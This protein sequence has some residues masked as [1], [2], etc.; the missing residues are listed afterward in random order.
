M[1]TVR[2][3]LAASSPGE[4]TDWLPRAREDIGSA[5]RALYQRGW[6][7]GT[8]GNVSVSDGDVVVISASGRAKGRMTARDTVAVRL[9]D[10]VPLPGESER[11][12]AETSIH[13]AVYRATGADA[14]VIHAHSPYATAL[15]ARHERYTGPG[16]VL[17]ERWELAKGLGMPE[18]DLVALPVFLNR[19]DVPRIAQEVT[20][21]LGQADTRTPP[22]LLIARHG[23]TVWGRDL[24]QARNRLEC[25]EALC[26]LALL[27]DGHESGERYGGPA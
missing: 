4:A 25:V 13:L 19:S 9:A 11:P 24:D 27:T 18:P 20:E 17:L 1:T 7:E 8:S 3:T 12:S 22:A 10:G 6:M 5:C 26:R 14:A 16:S 15:S 23:L 2:N 21:H